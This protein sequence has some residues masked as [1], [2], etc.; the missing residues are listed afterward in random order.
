MWGA[1][2]SAGG[3]GGVEG[4]EDIGGESNL[5]VSDSSVPETFY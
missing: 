3:G 5:L 4:V 2:V 1:L